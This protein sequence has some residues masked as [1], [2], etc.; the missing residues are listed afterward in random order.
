[1]RY[2]ILIDNGI[3][4]ETRKVLFTFATLAEAQEHVRFLKSVNDRTCDKYE[5]AACPE[6]AK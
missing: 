4:G 1:M 6:V 3:T 5:V 2:E